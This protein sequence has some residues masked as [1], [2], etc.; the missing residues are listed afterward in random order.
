MQMNV[1]MHDPAAF[2]NWF[3]RA[4][5]EPPLDELPDL[6]ER[7]LHLEGY[8][9]GMCRLRR[10]GIGYTVFDERSDEWLAFADLD[11]VECELKARSIQ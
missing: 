6:R 4:Y 5:G 2:A 9:H 8:Y 3:S 10:A 1:N 11:A 7:L